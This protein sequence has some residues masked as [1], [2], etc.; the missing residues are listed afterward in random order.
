MF[1]KSLKNFVLY[2][3]Y[4]AGS[5]SQHGSTWPSVYYV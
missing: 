4:F 1:S 3:R 5:A 2:L